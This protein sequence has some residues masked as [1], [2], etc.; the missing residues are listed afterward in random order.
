MKFSRRARWLTHIFTPSQTPTTRYPDS[1]GDDVSLTA[2]YDGG[3]WGI[4][5][6][7]EMVITVLSG[8]AAAQRDVI[9]LTAG[10]DEIIHLLA[11]GGKFTAGVNPTQFN[12]NLFQ[13]DAAITIGASPIV[14][15]VAVL[16][17]ALVDFPKI[18]PPTFSLVCSYDGGDAA[19]IVSWDVAFLRLPLGVSPSL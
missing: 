13:P 14:V 3:G 17:T 12:C 18:M 19:T 7:R 4:P 1:Y 16:E 9:V 11:V 6:P 8:A 2:P 15:P 10:V 5:D